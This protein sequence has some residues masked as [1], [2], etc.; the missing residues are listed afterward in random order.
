[1]RLRFVLLFDVLLLI[2]DE[3]IYDTHLFVV[4]NIICLLLINNSII[5][6]IDIN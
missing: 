6:S 3:N 4:Y 5:D 2:D 1:M